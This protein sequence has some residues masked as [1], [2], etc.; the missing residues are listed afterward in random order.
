MSGEIPSS[1]SATEGRIASAGQRESGGWRPCPPGCH[2]HGETVDTDQRR[3]VQERQSTVESSSFTHTQV[4][5]FN[6]MKL[7]LALRCTCN[8]GAFLLAAMASTL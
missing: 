5:R 6:A 4:G 7:L 8:K 3:G 1:G 2:C